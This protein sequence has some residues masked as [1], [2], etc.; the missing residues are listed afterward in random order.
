MRRG[1]AFV[2]AAW[3]TS[4]CTSGADRSGTE[5][6]APPDTVFALQLA[7]IGELDGAQEYLFGDISSA[8]AGPDGVIYVADRIG[9]TVRAYDA[10]GTYLGTVGSQGEGPG[11]FEWP[12]DLTFD[13]AGL[14]YARDQ[15]RI[16]VFATGPDGEFADSL[17]RTIPLGRFLPWSAHGRVYG[18]TYYFPSYYYF[19]FVTHRYFYQ[20]YD[21]TGATGDTVPVP[22]LP[23]ILFLARANYLINE[24]GGLNV[25]GINL[26]P[27][28]PRATWDI[29]PRGTL[30]T[31]EGTGYDIVE[32]GPAADTVR[33]ISFDRDPRAVP[34]SEW[35][36]SA[37]A[38]RERLDSVPV[39]LDDVNGM[40]DIARTRRPPDVLPEIHSIQSDADGYLWVRRW[41]S[42]GGQTV[43]DVL[44]ASGTPV[45]TV[46]LAADLLS[47]P[48][49]FVS[50]EL[51]VGVVRDPATGLERVAVF[52]ALG[53]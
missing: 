7:L 29:T 18:S 42:E 34:D 20:V 16:S 53:W 51:V 41:P 32:W 13:D 3:L 9:S 36:D 17:V 11:E 25:D 33:L 44:D 12:S 45:R 26:A 24:E 47:D 49:P 1:V 39:P 46:I 35:R 5:D 4:A 37:R 30:V 8:A 27:F 52:G 2:A 40:S 21:S 6:G 38:F 15:A 10:S 23:N 22:S 50:T 31:A 43:F 48:A 19:M 14:L 28:E